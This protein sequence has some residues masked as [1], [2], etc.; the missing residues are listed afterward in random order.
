M[1]GAPR[2]APALPGRALEAAVADLFAA[3]GWSVSRNV[4]RTGRS[5]ARHEVDVLAWRDDGLVATEVALECKHWRAPVDTEVVARARLLRD[6]LGVDR[7]VVVA[8][9]GWGPAAGH[10][11][12]DAGVV[13]WGAA[14]LAARIGADAVAALGAP[15]APAAAAGLARRVHGGDAVRALRVHAGGALGLSG[16]RAVWARAA[17][18]PL[19]E[20]RLA[21]ASP[22]GRMRR[23][24]RVTHLHVLQDAVTGTAL[25]V[26]TS[27]L[28]AGPVPLDAP[29]LPGDPGARALRTRLEEALRRRAER[30]QPAAQRRAAAAAARMGVPDDAGEVHVEE[31]RGLVLPVAVALVAGRRGRRLAVLDAHAG[32]IDDLLSDLVTPR[33]AEVCRALGEDAGG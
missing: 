28:A 27:P 22:A 21:C 10:A 20:I 3:R 16:E 31:V 6:D 1:H 29:V 30:V 17:W 15:P 33:L 11:A 12:R 13:L 23:R 5:G 9:G 18:L 19:A 25:R 14:E 26:E 8:P 2:S 32:R 4:V 24:L 7:A